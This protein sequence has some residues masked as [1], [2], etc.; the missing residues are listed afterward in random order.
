MRAR[1]STKAPDGANERPSGKLDADSNFNCARTQE[2]SSDDARAMPPLFNV[3]HGQRFQGA[4]MFRWSAGTRHV[5]GTRPNGTAGL[6]PPNRHFAGTSP[7]QHNPRTISQLMQKRFIFDPDA[8]KIHFGTWRR[9]RR[10]HFRWSA[11][12]RHVTGTRSKSRCRFEALKVAL[13][14]HLGGTTRSPHDL[15]V[16][17][18]KIRFCG[19]GA[20][21][22]ALA[23]AL[24]LVLSASK[25][26]AT[27]ARWGP[28][29]AL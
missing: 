3:G 16:D 25:A 10:L 14:R 6:R 9:L 20:G 2:C 18:D 12:T 27:G 7:A 23:L 4:G 17:A 11:G 13:C 22:L 28:S 1:S 15:A 26:L 24:A 8:K 19:G 29:A 21:D 5:T